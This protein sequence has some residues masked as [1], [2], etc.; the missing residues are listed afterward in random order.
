VPATADAR[1]FVIQ[2][3]TK[4]GG[5]A[6]KANGTLDGAVEEFGEPTSL[7]RGFYQGQ[8]TGTCV[9]RW[10]PLGLRITFYNLGGHDACEPQY[11]YFSE[12]LLTG[13]QWRTAKGLRIADPARRLWVLYNPRRFTGPWASL[14]TRYTRIGTNGYYAALEAKILRGRVTAFRVNYAAG[15]D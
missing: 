11:G 1:S 5:Y 2:G 14:L 8:P 15:G 6:V 4:I 13:N 3:D 7:R 10:R 12:A 9:A